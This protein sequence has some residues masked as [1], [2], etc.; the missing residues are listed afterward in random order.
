[1]TYRFEYIDKLSG[2]VSVSVFQVHNRLVVLFGDIHEKYKECKTCIS[3]NCVNIVKFLF[4]FSQD[5]PI[6]TDIFIEEFYQHKL[7][8]KNASKN[9]SKNTSKNGLKDK[10]EDKENESFIEDLR[11]KFKDCTC[12]NKKKCSE[13]KAPN[14]R[15]HSSDVRMAGS[16]YFEK[17]SF[18]NCCM[19]LLRLVLKTNQ[20]IIR[21]D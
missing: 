16:Q 4:E 18:I 10:Q 2:P 12:Q 17:R 7:S 9:T 13:I 11:N 21:M 20:R 3:P 15:F 6:K 19:T 8:S 5:V 1:M 14:V